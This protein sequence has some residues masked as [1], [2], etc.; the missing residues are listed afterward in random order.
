MHQVIQMFQ[1]SWTT[2]KTTK[3][4]PRRFLNDVIIPSSVRFSRRW[5][6]VAR[7]CDFWVERFAD[8]TLR[9]FVKVV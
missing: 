7:R 5:N 9:L 2:F 8:I 6:D 4:I 1:L 3:C